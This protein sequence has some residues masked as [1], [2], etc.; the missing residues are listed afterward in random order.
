MILEARLGVALG[1][2]DPDSVERLEQVVERVGLS[3]GIPQG[4][5]PSDILAY[6]GSDKKVRLGHTRFVLLSRIGAVHFAD[7]SW[8]QP[9]DEDAVLSLL[10][11]S[12]S[13]G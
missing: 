4:A 11:A 6:L 10:N 2:T 9:V 1:V 13:R 12:V 5:A 3:V 8:S 7:P